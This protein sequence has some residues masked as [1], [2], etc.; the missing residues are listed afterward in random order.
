MPHILQCLGA[1]EL[2]AVVGDNQG[3]NIERLQGA[4]ALKGQKYLDA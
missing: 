2:V 3:W 1:R 4:H